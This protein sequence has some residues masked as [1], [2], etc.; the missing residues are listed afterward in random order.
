MVSRRARASTAQRSAAM[1]AVTIHTSA[2]RATV[3]QTCQGTAYT[4]PPTVH[5][6]ASGV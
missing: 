3:G 4:Q 5:A 1:P 6:A 2:C